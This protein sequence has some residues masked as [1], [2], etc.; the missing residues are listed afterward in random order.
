MLVAPPTLS[1]PRGRVIQTKYLT[2]LLM[3]LMYGLQAAASESTQIAVAGK[4]I[5]HRHV[6]GEGENQVIIGEHV[7]DFILEFE[8]RQNAGAPFAAIQFRS[9]EPMGSSYHFSL[10]GSGPAGPGAVS[11]P[12]CRGLLYPLTLSPAA[13]N[14][15][16]SGEWNRFRIEMIGTSIRTSVNDQPV[17]HVI[18]KARSDGRIAFQLSP[19]NRDSSAGIQTEWRSVRLLTSNLQPS[20]PDATLI[21]NLLHNQLSESERIQGWKLLWDG[22]T[23]TGWRG[24]HRTTFPAGGWRIENGELVLA[25]TPVGE[26]RP[27]G[28]LVTEE[29]FSAFE[30]QFEFKLTAG[31]NSGV[32]Y[33]VTEDFKPASGITAI[34]LE[35]QLLDDEKH[36]DAARGANGN[37]KLASL[38]DIIPATPPPS[39]PGLAPVIGHWQHARIVVYP[40][41]QV[42]H[43]LN[44]VRVV[45]YVRGSAAYADA[46]AS[47]AYAKF[48]RFG[49]AEA[50]RILLQDHGDEVRFRSIKLRTLTPTDAPSTSANPRSP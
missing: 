16:R 14:A 15:A 33:F 28:D 20:P 32:K 40:N 46:V 10:W 12:G 29:L 41:Q 37:R 4:V 17:A 7:D 34:G 35:Y 27:G 19:A 39:E 1:G 30:L 21:R 23:S 44:G 49:L 11:E 43:W 50:G 9:Q 42:E 6:S 22:L 47:S 26:K 36:P 8:F 5:T 25:A 13:S 18:D 38:Y 31:A 3:G 45:D 48:P 2:A 24:A